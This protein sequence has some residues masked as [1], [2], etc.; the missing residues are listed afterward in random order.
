ML[1]VQTEAIPGGV[2]HSIECATSQLSS[3]IYE[4]ALRRDLYCDV[5]E[6]NERRVIIFFVDRAAVDTLIQEAT[7]GQR[8]T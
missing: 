7:R 1:T 3:E 8:S 6:S 4:A 2:A 5:D